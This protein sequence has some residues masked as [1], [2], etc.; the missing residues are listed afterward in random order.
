MIVLA[1]VAGV[2]S[3]RRSAG[4]AQTVRDGGGPRAA[5]IVRAGS[6]LGAEAC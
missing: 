2:A 5:P 3:Q 4:A 1:A 6:I